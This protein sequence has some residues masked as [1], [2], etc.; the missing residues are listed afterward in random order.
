MPILKNQRHEKA[1]QAFLSNGGN[2]SAA[3]RIGYPSSLKWKENTVWT[4]ANAL[5]NRAEVVSRVQELQSKLEKKEILSKEAILEDLREIAT[6]TIR[7]YVE[8]IDPLTGIVKYKDI[9]TWTKTMNRACTGIK[10]GRNGI[11]L[12]IYGVKYAYDRIS[13]MVGYDAP[14]KTENTEHTLADLLKK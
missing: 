8:S 4:N 11:E 14:I 2:K 7:D 5:F 9:N 10:P 12:T 3:Y 6:V 1:V 13:K